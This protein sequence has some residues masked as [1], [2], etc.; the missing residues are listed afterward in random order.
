MSAQPTR[1]PAR[2][3]TDA[4]LLIPTIQPLSAGRSFRSGELPRNRS[5]AGR[6][7]QPASRQSERMTDR[8]RRSVQLQ[9]HGASCVVL[10]E[11]WG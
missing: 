8:V 9:T 4:S 7:G 3:T 11:T 6:L 10:T 5:C 1:P 2:A